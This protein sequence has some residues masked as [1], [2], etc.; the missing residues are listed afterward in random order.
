MSEPI[1]DILREWHDFYVTLAAAAAGIL[2]AQFVVMSIGSGFLTQERAA[3]VRAFM[4]PTV[5]HLTGCVLACALVTVPGLDRTIFAVMV[6][7]GALMGLVFSGV[8]AVL[9]RRNLVFWEDVL[10]YASAPILAYLAMAGAALLLL[11]RAEW[12]LDLL[13]LSIA[14]L[15]VANIR[16]AWDMLV[17][18]VARQRRSE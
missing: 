2:G 12:S 16:N 6:G 18:L 13:A 14:L 3:S 9:Q 17:F 7:A 10:W 4:T 11:R 1:T 15:L 5:V 8:T